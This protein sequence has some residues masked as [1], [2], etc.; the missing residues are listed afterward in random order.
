MVEVGAIIARITLRDAGD[1]FHGELDRV[2][3]ISGRVGVTLLAQLDE[4]VV[5]RVFA[6]DAHLVGVGMA[7]E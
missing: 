6:E 1:Q 7:I 3:R 2:A 5:E 4:Q